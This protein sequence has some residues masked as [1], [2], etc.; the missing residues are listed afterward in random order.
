MSRIQNSTHPGGACL[1][2][3]SA[4]QSFVAEGEQTD[5]GLRGREVGLSLKECNNRVVSVEKS[6]LEVQVSGA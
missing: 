2:N 5:K 4:K 6:Y 3:N 1:Q